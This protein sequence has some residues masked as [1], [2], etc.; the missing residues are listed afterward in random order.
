MP[1]GTENVDIVRAGGL[2]GLETLVRDLGGDLEAGLGRY[3]L[4]PADLADPDRFL[5]YSSA[6]LA[7]EAMAVD[8]GAPDFGLRLSAL[9][10]LEFYG[11]LWLIIQSA[12]TVREGMLLGIKH[13]SFHVP[14]QGYRNFRSADGQL[15][16][17]EM[18]QRVPALPSLPQTAEN[19]VGHLHR[20]V[21]ALSDHKLRPTEIHFRHHQIGSEVQYRRHFGLLPHFS[22]DFDGIAV[23]PAGFRQPI[24]TQSPLL[25]QF[26]ERFL[27]GVTPDQ[28]QT[29]K[30]QV[31][32][33][34]HNL[35]RANMA[36]LATVAAVMGQHPRTLQ[37]RLAKE[38]AGFGA[39]RD[40]ARKD[41][42]SQLLAQRSLSLVQIADMLGYS[43]QSVLTHACQRWFGVTPL[44]LRRKL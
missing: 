42:A 23:S 6:V 36:E 30:Q 19:A 3:G 34:L 43:D 13:V 1:T 5:R 39:L 41:W 18:F 31:A 7:L 32:S 17:V 22:S 25:R 29:T 2:V 27:A 37:R 11:L 28:Q 44:R 38:G 16:C 20:I 21:L 8:L 4:K 40:E 26:V 12:P 35:V 9:Q 15:E 14:A 33:L 24:A 10:D